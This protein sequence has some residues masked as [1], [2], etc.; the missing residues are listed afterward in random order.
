MQQNVTG[1]T[2]LIQRMLL[3]VEAETTECYEMIYK[4]INTLPHNPDF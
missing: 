1:C 2:C 4:L 3:N